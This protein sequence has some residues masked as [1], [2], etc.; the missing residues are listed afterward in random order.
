MIIC[1]PNEPL[2]TGVYYFDFQ[3]GIFNITDSTFNIF[4][5]Q[6]NLNVYREYFE[7]ANI[8]LVVGL[9]IGN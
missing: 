9:T 4:F 5:Q 1:E 8:A 6:L 2:K 3:V 7:N